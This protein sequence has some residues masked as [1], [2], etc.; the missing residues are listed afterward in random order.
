MEGAVDDTDGDQEEVVEVA[1]TAHWHRRKA[2][3]ERQR[4][5]RELL[6]AIGKELAQLDVRL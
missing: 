4:A 3:L 5:C 1:G 6:R 2:C